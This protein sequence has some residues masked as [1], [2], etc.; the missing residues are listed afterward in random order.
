MM[1]RLPKR[2][3]PYEKEAE[4]LLSEGYVRDVQF[5]HD[6]YQIQV[7]DPTLETEEWTFLQL[8]DRGEIKDGFCSCEES[9]LNDT[10][11]H[12]AAAYERIFGGTA[13]PLHLRF[14][15]SLWNRLCHRQEYC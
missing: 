3:Q 8:S 1:N 11:V 14:Q 6:T 9:E 10:C 4:A 2:L 7:F 15:K 5:S 13:V 12:L